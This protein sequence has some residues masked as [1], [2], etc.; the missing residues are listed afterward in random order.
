MEFFDLVKNRRS[1]RKYKDQHVNKED[2]LKILD[3][4]NWAPSAMNWQPWEFIVV[5]GELIKSMGDSFKAVVEKIMH[6]SEETAFDEKFVDFAARYGGAPV[7]IVVLTRASEKPNVRKANLESTSAAMENL[8]LAA[9]NLGLGT[10]WM[11][12]PLHDENNLRRILGISPDKEIV[13]VTPLGYPD[14]VPEPRPRLDAELK[15][16]VRW[17]GY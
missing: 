5:S 10:C 7:V 12:G 14:E 4:A 15:Q 13:A 8:V 6:E 2:I 9:T 11:T 3:A 16:K 17:L 1:V